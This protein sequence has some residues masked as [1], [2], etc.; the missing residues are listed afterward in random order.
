[1]H[2]S[3][4]IIYHLLVRNTR[5]YLYVLVLTVLLFLNVAVVTLEPTATHSISSFTASLDIIRTTPSLSGTFAMGCHEKV[6]V[7]DDLIT[8]PM[9][10]P[11]A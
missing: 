9:S 11:V 3:S 5:S 10:S 2:N 1:M 6:F 4:L 7:R 8:G